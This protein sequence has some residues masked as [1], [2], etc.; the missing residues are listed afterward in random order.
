MELQFIKRQYIS[1]QVRVNYI[2]LMAPPVP[3]L[4]DDNDDDVNLPVFGPHLPPGGLVVSEP[5]A[6]AGYQYH[7]HTA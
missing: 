4:P 2:T 5:P 3:P 1:T 7:L 6:P